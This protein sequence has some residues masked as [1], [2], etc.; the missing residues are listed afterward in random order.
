SRYWQMIRAGR[1]AF[2][3][4]PADRWNHDAFF[5]EQQRAS[6]RYY[7]PHGAFID[8]VKSFAALEFGIPPRRVEVMDP[9]QRITLEAAWSAIQDAGYAPA[10]DRV[11]G[12]RTIDRRKVGT[13]LGLSCT[14]Y[15]NLM[16]SRVTAAMMAGGDLGVGAE[17]AEEA[18]RMAAAV[19][20]VVPTRA[21]SAPGALGNMSAA[22]VAQE[23]DLGGP[24]YTVDAA[25]ASALVAVHDA[26]TFLRDGQIDAAIAGGVYLNLTPENLIAFSR[27]GAISAKGVCRPFD[28]D[29]DGFVQGEGVGIVMLKRL[30]D[31]IRDHDRVYAVIRGSGVNND[32]RGDGPMSPRGDG[33]EAVIA[34]AWD[35]AGVLPEHI[36]YVEAHGTGTSVGDKTEL[37]ALRARL[38]KLDRPIP[39][40]SAKANVGHTMSAA[41]IAGLIKA[42]LAIHH[43]TIPP[44]AN[45]KAPHPNHD[46]EDGTFTVP[47][48]ATPWRSV[49]PRRATVSSFGFGGTNGHVVLEEAPQVRPG[50]IFVPARA[51]EPATALPGVLVVT[52]ADTGELL[53]K[54]CAELAE[55]VLEAGDLGAV[56]H[57]INLGRKRRAV[58]VAVVARTLEE[59]AAR[60]RKVADALAKDA[61]TRG[62]LDRD[63]IVGDAAT[64]VP[65]AFL[66]PGQGMQK[67]GMLR[68][69]LTLPAFAEAV[70][71]CESDVLDLTAR[72]LRQYIWGADATEEALTDTQIAQPAMF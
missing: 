59:L 15:R 25:C 60:F 40:G 14:E 63:T 2:G 10:L 72:P 69:W 13:F 58:R 38:G 71:T 22:A 29:A 16:S 18:K 39:L 6:D 31:A 28:A 57:T 27:I 34:Q 52:S 36:G 17:S 41:G 50:R 42:V 67:V 43:K 35:D 33:Q 32:G 11:T 68:E 7:A 56:A 66:C 64:P 12:G 70:E 1:H 3:T 53:Q 49:T 9:Q 23:L 61:T 62:A 37:G 20:R 54:H 26:V 46:L 4:P 44:L 8:D 45:W 21:F 55:T 19:G 48:E 51:P 65:V 47:T 24:A 30:E 5:S